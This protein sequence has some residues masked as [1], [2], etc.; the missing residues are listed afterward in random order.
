MSGRCSMLSTGL[1]RITSSRSDE[2]GA[3]LVEFVLILP[4]FALLL[5]AIVDFG[6]VFGGYISVQNQVNAA[7]RAIS[8]NAIAPAC[9][10]NA[11]PTL[12]TVEADISESPLGVVSGS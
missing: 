10:T 1:G 3:S 9:A 12:C 2:K 8:V 5:F 6:L 4:I 7:A 11:N